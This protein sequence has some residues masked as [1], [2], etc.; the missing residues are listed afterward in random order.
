MQAFQYKSKA[1]I[2]RLD[3]SRGGYAFIR[4]PAKVA[5]R[6]SQKHKTRLLCTIDQQLTIQCGLNHLGDGNFFIILGARYLKSLKKKAGDEIHFV[7]REDPD[8][9]GAPMPE[10]LEVLLEQEPALKAKFDAFTPGKKRM[11][12]HGILRLKDIDKQVH[13]ATQLITGELR[14][15]GRKQVD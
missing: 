15:G 7:I 6:C 10:V 13:K 8:P 4:I 5:D 12:I 14:P 11:V 3:K 9:L 2:E 1:L